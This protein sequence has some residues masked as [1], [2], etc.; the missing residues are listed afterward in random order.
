MHL[1]APH[2][3][4]IREKI[5]SGATKLLHERSFNDISIA[6]IAKSSGVSKGSV[7]YYYNS[8]DELLYDIADRYLDRAYSDLMV[9]VDDENK[10]TSLPR[11]IRYALTRGLDD[12]GKSLRL[13]L[14]VDAIAGNEPLRKK[15]LTK[16]DTFHKV[17]TEKISQRRESADGSYYAWLIL[18]L[19]DGLLI[20][21]L[22]RNSALDI[23]AFI[24]QVVAN[25]TAEKQ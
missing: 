24:E 20:Q 1:A 11:L 15:L 7:Y 17:F 18:T 23:P 21:E 2:N 9:W 10:D 8:K 19:I 5:L 12:S 22:M 14:T 4:N 13:H 3:D 16:Y 6:D 25:F